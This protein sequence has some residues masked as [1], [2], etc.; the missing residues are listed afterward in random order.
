MRF[1]VLCF[2]LV[3]STIV[4][5]L[6]TKRSER[7]ADLHLGHNASMHAVAALYRR[8]RFFSEVISHCVWLY[9]RSLESFRDV[10]EMMAVLGVTR[11]SASIRAWCLKFGQASA[12]ELRRRRPRPGERVALGRSV[13]PDQ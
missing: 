2:V 1:I 8:H 6:S 3:L 10:E 4:L 13:H 5:V 11:T 7:A 9:F 12:H